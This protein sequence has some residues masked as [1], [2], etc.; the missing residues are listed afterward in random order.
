MSEATIKK[1]RTPKVQSPIALTLAF[2][3]AATAAF[4]AKEPNAVKFRVENRD[5]QLFLRP[6]DRIKGRHVLPAF[7]KIPSGPKDQIKVNLTEADVESLG[8]KLEPGMKAGLQEDRYGWF[9]VLEGDAVGI[10][11][12]KMTVNKVA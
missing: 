11:G 10:E 12:A 3:A 5:G 2:N 9:Q 1:G 4:M 6:T 8:F 7:D